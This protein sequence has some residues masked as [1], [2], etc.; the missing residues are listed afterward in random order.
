M[1]IFIKT[2]ER[3]TS[4]GEDII[5]VHYTE[6]TFSF[7]GPREEL[8]QTVDNRCGTIEELGLFQDLLDRFPG[9]SMVGV[10]SVER[11]RYTH[12]APMREAL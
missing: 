11:V 2:I 7:R 9:R 1:A 4:E 3:S 10:E 12:R 5:H 8:Q 6:G